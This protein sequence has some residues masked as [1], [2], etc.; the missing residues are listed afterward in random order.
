MI[1]NNKLIINYSL[2]SALLFKGF[3]V[4]KGPILLIMLV[5]FLT[6]EQQGYW[7]LITNLG[8]LAFNADFGSGT[9]T[10]QHIAN[11]NK[12][13]SININMRKSFVRL[14]SSSYRFLYS[15]LAIIA[16]ILLPAGYILMHDQNLITIFSWFIYIASS[17]PVH[18]LL[19]ELFLLQGFGDVVKSYKLRSIYIILSLII[20]M[21][22]LA[23]GMSLLSLGISNV[24]AA[25]IVI[26]FVLR[27]FSAG[28]YEVKDSIKESNTIILFKTRVQ[29]I[30]SWLAGYAM[31]FM[32]VPIVMYFEGPIIAGQIGLG[33]ALVKAIS[34][35]SLAPLESNLILLGKALGEN[36]KIQF[37]N[38]FKK[39]FL[40]GVSIF[41]IAAL[42]SI[43]LLD[44]IQEISIFYNRL[45][46]TQIYMA[47]LISEFLYFVMNLLAKKVRIFLIEPYAIPNVFFG[48]TVF[49]NTIFWLAFYNLQL[50]SIMQALLYLLVGLP[51]FYKIYL[52]AMKEF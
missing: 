16:L 19:F 20:C 37:K 35:L 22:L 4:I 45:P 18:F 17:I 13:N 14:I 24:I 50:W 52:S 12:S 44:I 26:P 38:H 41:I 23:L 33:L 6:P 9:L 31:F 2:L 27:Q 15:S 43:F 32:I 40:I 1:S 51:L 10:M 30:T 46:D 34:A 25:L 39:S 36:D 11:H 21:V 8:A 42:I 29:Y 48:I 47:L 3:S 7:Y 28:K 49:C 5:F